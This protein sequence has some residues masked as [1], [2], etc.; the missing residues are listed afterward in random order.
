MMGGTSDGTLPAQC[1]TGPSYAS[2]N[3]NCASRNT[4]GVEMK[5]KVEEMMTRNVKC[6]APETNLAAAAMMMWD[7]DCGALPV[8]SDGGRAV[9]MITDR[10]IAIATAT[11]G[12][13]ASEICVR[14]VMTGQMHACAPG[15]NIQSALEMMRRCCVRRLPVVN[16]EGRLQGIL[17]I[18]DMIL[19]AEQSIGAAKTPGVTYEDVMSTMRALCEHRS[20]ARAGRV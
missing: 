7:N 13:R 4:K 18:N 3:F 15:D 1:G 5:V 14:E 10:D 8:V 16:H 11:Q 19:M 20:A 2:T 17:S 6:C 9:G 12:R